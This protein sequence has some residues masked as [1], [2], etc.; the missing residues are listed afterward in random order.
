MLNQ[1]TDKILFHFE[2][3][4]ISRKEFLEKSFAFGKQFNK[5][6]KQKILIQTD[7]YYLGLLAL[8]SCLFWKHIAVIDTSRNEDPENYDFTVTGKSNFTELPNIDTHI[9]DIEK[10]ISN[11][12]LSDSLSIIL[13][14]SGSGGLTKKIEKSWFCLISEVKFLKN[15]YQMCSSKA[16]ISLV[17]PFHIYGLLHSFLIP[18]YCKSSVY[19]IENL[20]PTLDLPLPNQKIDLLISTPS[21]WTLVKEILKVQKV[22]RLITSG[23]KFG[24]ERESQYSAISAPPD[25]GIEL[26]GSTETGGIGYR[27]LGSHSNYQLF[28][29]IILHEE[30]NDRYLESPFIFGAEKFKLEDEIE[31]ISKKEIRH[32]GRKDRIFK[33]SGKRYSLSSIE[34]NIQFLLNCEELVLCYF[35]ESDSHPKGGILYAFLE[36]TRK[37]DK[38]ILKKKYLNSFIFPFPEKIVTHSRFPKTKL[39]KVSLEQLLK[40]VKT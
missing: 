30:K 25:V 16:T 27:F 3:N 13:C 2:D 23:S 22:D 28:P 6:S 31:I 4:S 10:I 18:L 32:L 7:S 24:S 36:T 37:I 17:S 19:F 21:S 35:I 5:K 11:N 34:K 33:Y 14:T 40:E 26:I 8:C 29:D 39:G 15:F 12:L 20:I 38:K 1:H 9:P